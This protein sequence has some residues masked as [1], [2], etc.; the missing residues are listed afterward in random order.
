[1]G[2]AGVVDP[3]ASETSIRTLA[4]ETTHG[5]ADKLGAMNSTAPTAQAMREL[6][7]RSSD[8]IDVTLFWRPDTDDLMV[9]VSDQRRGA[10][11]ELE[12]DATH[13]LDAFHHP[14]AYA[15][16]SRVYYEDERLAA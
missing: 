6:A 8:G 14:Y 5:R 11:F 16:V 10:Y 15:T 2:L 9:C 4:A 3:P 7:H 13:A 1:V 12:P